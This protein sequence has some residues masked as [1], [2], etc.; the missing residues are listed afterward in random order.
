M[1]YLYQ[2]FRRLEMERFDGPAGGSQ[3]NQ[4]LRDDI[5]AASTDYRNE[6]GSESDADP[7]EHSAVPRNAR[8]VDAHLVSLKLISE[9]KNASKIHFGQ[10]DFKISNFEIFNLGSTSSNQV[11]SA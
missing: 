1:L 10:N 9:K 3:S 7:D 2:L 8:G 4:L 11:K 6:S 5:N